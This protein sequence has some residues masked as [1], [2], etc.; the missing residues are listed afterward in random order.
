M[1]HDKVLYRS[2]VIMGIV[3]FI[4]IYG[5][6]VLNPVYDDWLLGRGD[7]TQHYLGWCFTGAAIG[8]FLLD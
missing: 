2:S 8:H 4:A 7:L 5:I 3:A 6:N 1:N